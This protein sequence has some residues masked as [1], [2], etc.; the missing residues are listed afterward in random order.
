MND[1][2]SVNSADLK[3]AKEMI[4]EMTNCLARIDLERESL[5]DIAAAIEDKTGIKKKLSNKIARTM[6]K[7]NYA[8]I[9]SENE[10]FE[11]LY[12]AIAEGKKI[13]EVDE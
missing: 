4:T 9:Q 8:D 6:F 10:H 2:V 11:F 12:E 1:N 13:N 3:K 5:K 7:H